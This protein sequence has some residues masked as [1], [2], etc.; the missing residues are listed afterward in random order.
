[1]GTARPV[2]LGGYT[3][4]VQS[5]SNG[6]AENDKNTQER[7]DLHYPQGRRNVF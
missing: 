4:A 2:V 7:V 1:M 3:I 5:L 6:I